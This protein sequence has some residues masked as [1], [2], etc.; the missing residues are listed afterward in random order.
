MRKKLIKNKAGFGTNIVDLQHAT[1]LTIAEL[2]RALKR[3]ERTAK[4]LEK[5]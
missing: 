1:A 3:S 4:K 5:K 2:K